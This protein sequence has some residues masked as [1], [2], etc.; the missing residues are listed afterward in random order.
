MD[1][2]LL[3]FELFIDLMLNHSIRERRNAVWIEAL[4]CL[5][6]GFHDYSFELLAIFVNHRFTCCPG[7]LFCNGR[8]ESDIHGQ[9][10]IR[11]VYNRCI[12]DIVFT[13]FLAR[14]GRITGGRKK[15]QSNKEP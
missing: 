9:A 3:R 14:D 4:L 11:L 12:Y 5:S 2:Y 1:W 13:R 7:A 10:V 8:V 15:E 6:E